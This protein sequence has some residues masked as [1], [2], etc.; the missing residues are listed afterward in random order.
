[1][2]DLSKDTDKDPEKLEKDAQDKDTADTDN[3][4]DTKKTSK[5]G[6]KKLQD[7]YQEKRWGKEDH[8]HPE[9]SL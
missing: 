7:Y 3:K 8:R 4:K 2:I 6:K 9:R 1:M 5:S